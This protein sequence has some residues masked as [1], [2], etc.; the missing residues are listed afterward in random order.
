MKSLLSSPFSA[1][2]LKLQQAKKRR[3]FEVS[4]FFSFS[5]LQRSLPTDGKEKILQIFFFL[6]LFSAP[7]V[8][9]DGRQREDSSNILLSSLSV[10]LCYSLK[11]K[12]GRNFPEFPGNF[13]HLSFAHLSQVA[14]R[15]GTARGIAV[16][17]A[18]ASRPAA[19]GTP[20]AIVGAA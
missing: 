1:L 7:A 19:T 4:S 3:F 11:S 9:P 6:L 8:S 15:G 13:S 12:N 20:L 2:R 10:S 16:A 18:I 5:P 17:A 14:V